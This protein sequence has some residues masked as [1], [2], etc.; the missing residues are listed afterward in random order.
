MPGPSPG[1]RTIFSE[2][3]AD[4][5]ARR[6]HRSRYP[7][8]LF[9]ALAAV[10]QRRR[11]RDH[12]ALVMAALP[13]A[14]DRRETEVGHRQA[15][16]RRRAELATEIA[17]MASTRAALA[18]REHESMAPYPSGRLPPVH[19]L[20]PIV[21]FYATDPFRRVELHFHQ[22][23]WLHLEYHSDAARHVRLR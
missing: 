12:W 4:R 5:I 18:V 21:W 8:V 13:Q 17:S 6:L 20:Y 1:L 11:R 22:A 19:W 14:A 16:L 23:P 7:A 2:A 9:E 10:E 3:R 15:A